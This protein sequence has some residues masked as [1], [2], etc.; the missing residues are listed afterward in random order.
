MA[1]EPARERCEPH[2]RGD[3]DHELAGDRGGD[4]GKRGA[5][6]L[7]LDREHQ[8]VG[9]RGHRVRSRADAHA[10]RRDLLAR[11]GADLD[12]RDG[13]RVEALRDEAADQGSDSKEPGQHETST[14]QRSV[15]GEWNRHRDQR[16]QEVGVSEV[17]IGP[18]RD[19]RDQ[20]LKRADSL[21]LS[22]HA[23]F[24]AIMQRIDSKALSPAQRDYFTYLNAWSSAYDGDYQVAI[25]ALEAVIA[26]QVGKLLAAESEFTGKWLAEH[27]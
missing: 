7:R 12:H 8:R 13:A 18:V 1:A 2:A 6:I 17:A 10:M 5:R 19:L 21:R 4:R 25:P 9:F 26:Q 20:L 23:E 11:R 15:E 24:T 14:P 3:A 27:G 16:A 22:N